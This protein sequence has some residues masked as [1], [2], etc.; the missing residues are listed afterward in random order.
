MFAVTCTSVVPY[1]EFCVKKERKREKLVRIHD[2][3]VQ[4]TE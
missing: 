1:P 2:P 3:W 4:L